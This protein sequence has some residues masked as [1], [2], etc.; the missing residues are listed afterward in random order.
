MPRKYTNSHRA[1]CG[2]KQN[3]LNGW[4]AAK[5]DVHNQICKA[6][7]SGPRYRAMASSLDQGLDGYVSAGS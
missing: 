7:A 4:F 6:E 2:I 5:A 3:M 1:R